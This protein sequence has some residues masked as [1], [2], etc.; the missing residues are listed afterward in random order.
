M[1]NASIRTAELST[2]SYTNCRHSRIFNQST[3]NNI[4]IPV[5]Y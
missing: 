5:Y 4:N 3:D 2:K 1:Y